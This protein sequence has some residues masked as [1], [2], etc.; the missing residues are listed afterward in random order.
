M[1]ERECSIVS[2]A[3]NSRIN[4]RLLTGA[5]VGAAIPLSGLGTEALNPTMGSI[6]PVRTVEMTDRNCD[7]NALA[8][9]ADDRY[10]DKYFVCSN[11]KYVGLFCPV[12]MAF[13][14]GLQE[15][16]LRPSVDCSTRP[17]TCKLIPFYFHLL[18]ILQERLVAQ[19]M[20]LS[21]YLTVF[22]CTSF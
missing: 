8:R 18:Y 5:S 10:C 3:S 21:I 4:E 6:Q 9:I 17:L 22:S 16:R 19:L 7:K 2:R 14:Y 15:C 20:T 11:N 1:E 13:D 12:G